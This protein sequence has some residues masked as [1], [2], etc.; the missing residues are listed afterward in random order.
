MHSMSLENL[1]RTMMKFS[2]TALLAPNCEVKAPLTGNGKMHGIKCNK[3]VLIVL[4]FWCRKL[5]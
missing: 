3:N 5:V 2:K 1:D 4:I